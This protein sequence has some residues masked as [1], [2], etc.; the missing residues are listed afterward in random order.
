MLAVPQL[1]AH[2]SSDLSILKPPRNLGG[3]C[4]PPVTYVPRRKSGVRLA[5]RTPVYQTKCIQNKNSTTTSVAYTHN[6]NSSKFPNSFLSLLIS[7]PCYRVPDSFAIPAHSVVRCKEL[8]AP[9]QT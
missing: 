6:P 1:G 4:E 5:M 7:R 9:T 2:L 8:E 3:S